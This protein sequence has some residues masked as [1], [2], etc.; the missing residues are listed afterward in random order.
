LFPPPEKDLPQATPAPEHVVLSIGIGRAFIQNLRQEDRR[1]RSY[2]RSIVDVD[3]IFLTEEG[4]RS[5][6]AMFH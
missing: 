6:L 1:F 2:L 3:Q 5:A 4:D